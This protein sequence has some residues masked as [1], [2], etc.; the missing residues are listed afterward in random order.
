M[1]NKY[2][3]AGNGWKWKRKKKY[4]KEIT[5]KSSTKQYKTFKAY[6]KKHVVKKIRYKNKMLQ[7]YDQV[8]SVA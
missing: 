4:L 3:W 5:I 2:G 1:K 6:H 8:P 7:I